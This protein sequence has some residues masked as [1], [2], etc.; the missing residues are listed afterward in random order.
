VELNI[1]GQTL[2]GSSRYPSSAWQSMRAPSLED[3]EA[4]SRAA[5]ENM[6]VEFKTLC[7]ELTIRV[8]DFPTD[9]MIEELDLETPFDVLGLF[10]GTDPS[11][12]VLSIDAAQEPNVIHLYRRAIIDYWAENEEMLGD[13]IAYVMLHEIGEHFGL[14][15]DDLEELELRV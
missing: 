7:H 3:F 11:Q 5:W 14:S 10:E 6:P 15:D 12:P 13:V 4:L 1:H 2:V 8:T 9:E